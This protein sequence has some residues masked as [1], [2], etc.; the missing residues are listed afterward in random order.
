MD[1]VVD[2]FEARE[3]AAGVD[4][5]E[6]GGVP[7]D[8]AGL[9]VEVPVG[10]GDQEVVVL[11]LAVEVA[12]RDVEVGGS[13]V[14]V[15]VDAEGLVDGGLPGVVVLIGVEWVHD[16]APGLLEALDLLVVLPLSHG[17]HQVLV[18]DD[19]AVAEHHLV[20]GR[21]DLLDALVVRLGDV[22]GDYLPSGRA[23]VKL[24]DAAC[25]ET[26]LPCS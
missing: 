17:H 3:G 23:E 8:L 7:A 5:G 1:E 2:A 20:V 21:V 4:D 18:L 26:Y 22:L 11:Q 9:G 12:G 25:R 16:V 19:S 13:A 10:L 15:E 14:E 24:G 6:V